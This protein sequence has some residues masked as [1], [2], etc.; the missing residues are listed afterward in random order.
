M[1]V[2]QIKSNGDFGVPVVAW[3]LTNSTGIHEDLGSIPGLASWVKDLALLWLWCRPGAT[4]LIGL[5]AW[6][7]SY[8]TGVDLKKNK[9]EEKKKE[10]WRL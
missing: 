10:Q 4:A 5:L 7:P 1:Q 3:W 6:E 8:A 2:L 9:K